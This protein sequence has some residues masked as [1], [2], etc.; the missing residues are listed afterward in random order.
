MPERTP[1]AR[2]VA[3]LSASPTAVQKAERVGR[4]AREL[5]GS[6]DVERV[7]CDMTDR[8]AGPLAHSAADGGDRARAAD[9]RP[10]G[11]RVEEERRRS[12]AAGAAGRHR[13]GYYSGGPHCLE[14][15]IAGLGPSCL[16]RRPES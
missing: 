3:R 6:W 1:S 4:I 11:R 12:T 15:P 8:P 16:V 2:E 10:A 13:H 14:R 7:R 9:P 5:D